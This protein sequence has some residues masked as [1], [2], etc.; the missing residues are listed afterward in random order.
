MVEIKNPAIREQYEVFRQHEG[1]LIAYIERGIER[2]FCIVST[3]L[4]QL[5]LMYDIP[6]ARSGVQY[7]SFPETFV[8]P[9]E[10]DN[11]Q[12]F[13]RR[14]RFLA[15]NSVARRRRFG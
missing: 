2:D 10:F 6:L 8:S 15:G 4:M 3:H 9:K 5:A 12:E 13:I 7:M 11:I 14:A 1:E